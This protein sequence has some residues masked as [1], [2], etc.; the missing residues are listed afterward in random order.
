MTQNTSKHPDLIGSGSL[1]APFS[2]RL[3]IR[4]TV[5]ADSLNCLCIA[6]IP[7]VYPGSTPAV[8]PKAATVTV[9]G[10]GAGTQ[11]RITLKVKNH[12]ASTANSDVSFTIDCDGAAKVDWS[13]GAAVAYSLKDIIDLINEADAGG[14]SGKL[15]G[16]FR[17]WIAEG[18]HYDMVC[19]GAAQF[20]DLAATY[21]NRPGNSSGYTSF[22]KRDMAVAGSATSDSDYYAVYRLGMPE[23]RDRGMFKLLD[24]YG[25]IGTDIGGT[26]ALDAGVIVMRDDIDDYVTPGGT[27]AT[28]LANHEIVYW[29][30]CANLPAGAGATS[31]S[32]TH[33]PDEAP[34]IRGPVVLL[35]KANTDFDAQAVNITAVLQ[36]VA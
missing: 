8:T 7:E 25:S 21:I 28:D 14:T 32:L 33:T 35:V 20:Q 18:G 27:W 36:A 12:N 19:N 16:G 31:N 24:L 17:C 3:A 11:L 34:V 10:H 29:V 5:D 22:L 23:P 2:K 13:S 4:A 6:Y 30:D 26:L 1:Q 9:D 15:L